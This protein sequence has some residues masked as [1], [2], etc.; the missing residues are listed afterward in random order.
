[1]PR[2]PVLVSV[3]PAPAFTPLTKAEL[4]SY[5][6]RSLANAELAYGLAVW[7]PGGAASPA[8]R[9]HAGRVDAYRSAIE[10]AELMEDGR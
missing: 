7:A 8:A 9:Y 4:V 3:P 5:L 10:L 2:Q 1:M 6:E